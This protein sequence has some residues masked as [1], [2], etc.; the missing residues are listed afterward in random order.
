MVLNHGRIEQVGSSLALYDK[1]ANLF[2][3]G[4]IGSPAMNFLLGRVAGNGAGMTVAV[5]GG[6]HL[7][8]PGLGSADAG[9]VVVLGVRPE[10]FRLDGAGVLPLAVGV[11]EPTGRDIQVYGKLGQHDVCALFTGRHRLQTGETSRLGV[12][13]AQLHLFDAASG[14]SLVGAGAA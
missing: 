9:R 7:P 3:A 10:D 12:D 14:A 1:P 5:S 8:A 6:L 13:P 4:F 2:L 11:I